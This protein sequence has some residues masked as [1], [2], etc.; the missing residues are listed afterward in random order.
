MA[1]S[2]LAS[3]RH[4]E[5][6]VQSRRTPVL[7][8]HGLAESE[9]ANTPSREQKYWLRRE[10][11]REHLNEM[12]CLGCRVIQLRDF[13]TGAMDAP[14]SIPT[15]VVT[16]DDGLV[17][18]YE[19]AYPLLADAGLYASFFINTATVGMQGF[20]T[21]P[22]I[23]EM[24]R[25]GMSFQSHSHDH[26]YLTRLP[27]DALERQLHRSKRILED[28][29]GQQVDFL[30]APYG[31]LNRR[32]LKAAQREGYKAVCSSWNWSAR[33]RTPVVSRAVIDRHT[34]LRD[35]RRLLTGSPVVYTARAVRG[36]LMYIPKRLLLRFSPS[37]S[38]LGYQPYV[39]GK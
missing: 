38:P 17:S 23:I 20:L 36:C 18:A 1:T 25:A 31:D 28:H 2:Q 22:R 34:T 3:T 9:Q 32:I 7:L 10:V 5:P 11:F 29:L 24:Q 13:W 4:G 19:I 37:P 21:W 8:Y 15:A 14:R 35:F 12:G 16:F 33:P 30:S 26:I 6:N 39:E 27:P